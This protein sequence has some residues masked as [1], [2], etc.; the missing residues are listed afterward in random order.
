MSDL[1]TAGEYK[2]IAETMSVGGNAFIDGVS[3]PGD[4]GQDVPDHQPRHRQELARVAACGK[5]DVDLAV[6]KAR[7]AFEDGRWRGPP[8]PSVSGADGVRQA[9]RAQP[10]RVGGAREPG[11]RQA[12]RRVPDDRRPRDDQHHPLARGADRQDLRQHGPVGQG[13]LALVVREPIG[14]VGCVL[15]WNFPLL[16]MAWKIGPALAAGCSV[17]VKPAEETSLTALRLAELPS[18]PACRPASSMS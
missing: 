10:A 14:V 7:E 11:Q 3:R 1:L 9:D 2:A 17:I 8:R 18:R 6:R 5:A 4:L 15:P 12:G 16:M 13:A